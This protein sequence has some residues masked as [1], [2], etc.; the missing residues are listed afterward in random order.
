MPGQLDTGDYYPVEVEDKGYFCEY[1]I[2]PSF[3]TC[4]KLK[5][6]D[7]D[8]KTNVFLLEGRYYERG[9]NSYC[10]T[11]GSRKPAPHTVCCKAVFG[12]DE[13]MVYL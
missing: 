9:G 6:S 1:W 2:R 11:Y 8:T 10:C 4:L 5:K 7:S 13:V 3:Q 12:Y